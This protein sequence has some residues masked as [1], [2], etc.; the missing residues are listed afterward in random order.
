[1]LTSAADSVE[2]LITMVLMTRMDFEVLDA[3]DLMP[4]LRKA[5]ERLT[6]AF[7]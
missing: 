4:E 5:T 3:Q 1:M 2:M 6:R 7:A